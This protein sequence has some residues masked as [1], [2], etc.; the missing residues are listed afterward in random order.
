MSWGQ[1]RW[2]MIKAAYWVRRRELLA[3]GNS[4]VCDS[5][6]DAAESKMC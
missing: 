2:G 5:C 3:L 1:E 6:D 4:L